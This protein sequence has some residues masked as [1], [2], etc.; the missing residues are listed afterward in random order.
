MTCKIHIIDNK[1]WNEIDSSDYGEKNINKHSSELERFIISVFKQEPNF[2]SNYAIQQRTGHCWNRFMVDGCREEM[3]R[4][5]SNS[6]WNNKFQF[7]IIP[8]YKVTV[9]LES[10]N[11]Q[12]KMCNIGMKESTNGYSPKLEAIT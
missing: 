1:N 10:K 3:C 5:N 7:S 9:K 11:I 2:H 12:T 4:N 8:F 6:K